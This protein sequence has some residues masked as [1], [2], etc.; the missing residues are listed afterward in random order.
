MNIVETLTSGIQFEVK[1]SQLFKRIL[2]AQKEQPEGEA[3]W[4]EI[5]AQKEKAIRILKQALHGVEGQSPN[6]SRIKL[7]PAREMEE[8]LAWIF[9]SEKEL[10]AAGLVPAA[11]VKLIPQIA[12]FELKLIYAP[13][14]KIYNLQFVKGDPQLISLLTRHFQSL[15]SYL[16]KHHAPSLN[17]LAKDYPFLV[18]KEN[19]NRGFSENDLYQDLTTRKKSVTLRLKDGT[20]FSG[21]INSFDHFSLQCLPLEG[22]DDPMTT[23]FLKESILSLQIHD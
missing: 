17:A 12:A 6:A 15:N 4:K 11:L 10:T 1:I 14:L 8:G 18:K 3:I 19:E 7:L 21:K 5:F 20:F 23:L 22:S 13:L 16:K 2:A 9:K